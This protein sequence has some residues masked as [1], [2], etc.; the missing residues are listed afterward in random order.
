MAVVL[1]DGWPTDKVEEASRHARESGINVFLITMEGAVENE[2][3]YIVEPNFVNKVCNCQRPTH[4]KDSLHL[5]K[6]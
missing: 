5:A 4:R 2:K 3:P 1:V 6:L